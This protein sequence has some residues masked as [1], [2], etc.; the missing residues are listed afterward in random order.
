MDRPTD[1]T[2]RSRKRSLSET[3]FKPEEFKIACFVL[4]CGRKND[5]NKD[6]RKR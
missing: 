3:L 6:F 2:N 5:K 1:H 4:K